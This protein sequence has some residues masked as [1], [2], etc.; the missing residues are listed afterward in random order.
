[1]K[2]KLRSTKR[3]RDELSQC[4]P[5]VGFIVW[6][7]GLGI[8]EVDFYISPKDKQPLYI[9]NGKPVELDFYRE[10]IRECP[11]CNGSGELPEAQQAWDIPDAPIPGCP[12]CKESQC[13][14]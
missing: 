10:E 14:Q 9:A 6:N 13:T 12:Y 5:G 8:S 7:N 2:T 1:M 11:I 3:Q 4:H